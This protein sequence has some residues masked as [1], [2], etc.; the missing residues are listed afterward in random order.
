MFPK[1][2]VTATAP[3]SRHL[4]HPKQ[5]GR[6]DRLLDL[7]AVVG[8]GHFPLPCLDGGQ[9]PW[10]HPSAGMPYPWEPQLPL[11]F[12]ARE[13]LC[14]PLQ[15]TPPTLEHPGCVPPPAPTSPLQL[16]AVPLDCSNH[17]VK[18]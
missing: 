2:A 11:C 7:P 9:Q 10:E 17:R 3:L 16:H 13:G 6:R 1:G 14:Q 5:Q 4:A 8:M 12:V 15:I 18:P